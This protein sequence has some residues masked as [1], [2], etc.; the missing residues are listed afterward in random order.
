MKL[1][2]LLEVSSSKF[3]PFRWKK[4]I[5][6]MDK[7]SYIEVIMKRTPLMQKWEKKDYMDALKILLNRKKGQQLYLNL[8]VKY[9]S[10]KIKVA[11][12]IND[13]GYYYKEYD[14]NSNF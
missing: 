9:W 13:P 8:A 3:N 2:S 7:P 10:D 1:E 4:F 14:G 12:I 5:D 6:E 11:Q